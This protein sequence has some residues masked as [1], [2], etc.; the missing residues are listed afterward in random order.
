MAT[1]AAGLMSAHISET[2]RAHVE[3]RRVYHTCHDMDQG[4]KKLLIDAFEDPFLNALSDE[5]IG[6]ANF[7]SLQFI[8]HLL[9]YYSMIATTELT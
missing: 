9:T 2:N 4:F 3:A 5:V 8:S 7:T 1:I 6:Y